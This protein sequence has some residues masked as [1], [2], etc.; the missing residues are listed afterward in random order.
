MSRKAIEDLI[1]AEDI[2]KIGVFHI[3]HDDV[4]L[5]AQKQDARLKYVK[6]V[7]EHRANDAEKRMIH[8]EYILKNERVFRKTDDGNKWAIPRALRRQITQLCHDEI[9]VVE[10]PKTTHKIK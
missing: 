4:L 3:E 7:L 5:L 6:E 10:I 2:K 8:K 9:V 1:N